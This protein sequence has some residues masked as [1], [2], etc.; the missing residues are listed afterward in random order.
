M[1]QDGTISTANHVL[2]TG[3]YDTENFHDT[4]WIITL[5]LFFIFL[6]E[7]FNGWW[8]MTPYYSG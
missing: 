1:G 2:V 4:Y 5:G 6:K 8:T 3:I 7:N